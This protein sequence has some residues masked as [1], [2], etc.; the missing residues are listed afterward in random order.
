MIG[1]A[2]EWVEDCAIEDAPARP[3]ERQ[4][5]EP[6]PTCGAETPRILKGGS[7]S[8]RP[9]LLEVKARIGADVHVR[10]VIAGF[11]VLH[12]TSEARK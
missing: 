3:A 1:N 8:D 6:S 9:D 4:S 5:I 2:W 12:V 11:R 10:D 7:W